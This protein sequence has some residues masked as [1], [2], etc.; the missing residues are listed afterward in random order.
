LSVQGAFSCPSGTEKL[1][2]RPYDPLS[3]HIGA[4][5]A[6]QIAWSIENRSQPMKINGVG[7]AISGRSKSS[8]RPSSVKR[9]KATVS[10]GQDNCLNWMHSDRILVRFAHSRRR[11][12]QKSQACCM[13]MLIRTKFSDE[14][15]DQNGCSDTGRGVRPLRCSER[16][17]P[18]RVRLIGLSTTERD[19]DVRDFPNASRHRQPPTLR[20]ETLELYAFRFCQGGFRELGMTFEQFVLVVASFDL[21]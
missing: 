11:T 20:N 19:I 15:S 18:K 10:I 21:K 9:S 1:D 12:T 7:A 5:R 2:V 6:N 14:G 13:H 8:I 4:V 17:E 3:E 16:N